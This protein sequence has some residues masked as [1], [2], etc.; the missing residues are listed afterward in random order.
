[1]TPS[2]PKRALVLSG[3]G[4]RGAYAAGILRYILDEIPASLGRPIHFDII[5]G[6]S[7]GAINATWLASSIQDPEYCGQRLWYL[8]RRMRMADT[9]D[10]SYRNA[11][12]LF[13]RL[14]T[15]GS[16]P[17]LQ[18]RKGRTLSLLNTEYFTNLIHTEIPFEQIRKNIH[19]DLLDALTVT[20][21]EVHTGRTTV[22]VESE[23]SELPPWTRDPR[24]VARSGQITPAKVL[25]SA[26]I[27]VLFPAV[28]V[29]DHWFFDGGLRQ[30]TPISPALRMG[31]TKL[32]VISL[33]S[34]PKPRLPAPHLLD[35]P[36]TLSFLAGKLLNALLLDPL[37]YDLAL[38]ERINGILRH[39]QKALDD[40]GEGDF[41]E[42]LNEVI[43]VYRGQGY[44]LVES[45]LLRPT[46]DLGELATE[47]AASLSDEEWGSKV[48]A[49]IGR[50][51]ANFE[52]YRESDFLSYVLFDRGYTGTL[53]DLGWHDAKLQHDQL[54]DFFED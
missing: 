43:E 36:P 4:A 23:R 22:F 10:V 35:E 7:V 12:T 38:M 16:S 9:V 54:I 30:N 3:G 42:K 24:R 41:I 1:M 50:R 29:G 37:D 53:L 13:T 27:P 28:R 19:D 14:V 39:G 48:M 15:D 31:A 52:G 17:A 46:S 47:F 18:P 26:A 21:T 11:M 34:S 32:M 20:A 45:M 40:A 33:K 5:S 6:T 49:T 44:R 2:R 8:W 51:A 25:A